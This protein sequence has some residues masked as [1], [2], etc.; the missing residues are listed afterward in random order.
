MHCIF[1][2]QFRKKN[3]VATS[4]AY[5]GPRGIYVVIT[6]ITDD[7]R[8]TKVDLNKIAKKYKYVIRNCNAVNVDSGTHF[9]G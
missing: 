1:S 5:K 3:P 9:A 4:I 8:R 6:T 7:I 2:F